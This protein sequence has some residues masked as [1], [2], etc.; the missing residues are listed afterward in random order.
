MAGT[1]FITSCGANPRVNLHHDQKNSG[2]AL[3]GAA[4]SRL[5]GT[6]ETTDVVVRKKRGQRGMGNLYEH[7]R[8]WWLDVRAGG[9]RHRLKLGPCKVLEK[10]EA[11]RIADERIKHLLMPKPPVA[12]D[13]VPFSAFA[14]KFVAWATETKIGW[15]Q[16]RGQPPD[17]TAAGMRVALAFFGDTPLRDITR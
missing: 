1:V 14:Q 3:R 9:A 17:R 12:K 6:M 11:R 15:R 16:Y 7:R 2:R 8:N 5:E 10:R 13:A 4:D